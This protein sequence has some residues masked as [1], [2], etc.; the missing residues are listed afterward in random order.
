MTQPNLNLLN[1]IGEDIFR[2]A[3]DIVRSIPLNKVK[4][5][6]ETFFKRRANATAVY[7]INHYNAA[8][9]EYSCSNYE[10]GREVFI[11]S[12]TPVFV[13]FTY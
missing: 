5:S 10:T 8:D 2:P 11:K 1:E 7:V 3:S 4:A 12:T 6:G 9:R 13:G